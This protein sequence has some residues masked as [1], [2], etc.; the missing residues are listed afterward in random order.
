MPPPLLDWASSRL[1]WVSLPLVVWL[2][3][4]FLSRVLARVQRRPWARHTAWR[5]TFVG[6]VAWL[7]IGMTIHTLVQPA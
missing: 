4:F 3:A 2:V 6:V 7:V 5:W 1:T